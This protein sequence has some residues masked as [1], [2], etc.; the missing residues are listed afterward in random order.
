MSK[1][2]LSR[3]V[4]LALSIA[5]SLSLSVAV[6]DAIAAQGGEAVAAMRGSQPLAEPMLAGSNGAGAVATARDRIG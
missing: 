2:K 1:L 4:P 6:M 3:A 5:L